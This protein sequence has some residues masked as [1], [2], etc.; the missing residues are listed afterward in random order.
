MLGRTHLR[1]PVPG[2]RRTDG[3]TPGFVGSWRSLRPPK[4]RRSEGGSGCTVPS[5][6]ET[7]PKGSLCK[8]LPFLS[9]PMPSTDYFQSPPMP[10]PA[11]RAP[12]RRTSPPLGPEHPPRPG[13]NARAGESPPRDVAGTHP[14][15]W[16]R[17]FQLCGGRA[18]SR[19]G[20]GQR[21]RDTWW[22]GRLNT[23]VGFSIASPTR[24]KNQ[25][26]RF[27]CHRE[28]G[29]LGAPQNPTRSHDSGSPAGEG[30]EAPA[31]SI[32]PHLNYS[33]SN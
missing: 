3:R 25:T 29:F 8:T 32:V 18:S 19:S 10:F 21:T 6:L 33:K 20:C 1:A 12:T 28:P 16:G 4:Q 7:D 17:R 15:S 2:G 30:T 27:Q 13:D 26:R 11:C 9:V 22:E 24:P 31:G 5:P 14:R 23:G